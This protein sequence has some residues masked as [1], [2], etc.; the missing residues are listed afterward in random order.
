MRRVLLCCT[1]AM[2]MFTSTAMAQGTPAPKEDTRW[3]NFVKVAEGKFILGTLPRM[4]RAID[5][6][7]LLA[8][9]SSEPDFQAVVRRLSVAGANTVCFDLTGY[10]TDG[11]SLPADIAQQ[12]DVLMEL[13]NYSRMGAICRVIPKDA[14]KSEAFCMSAV[15]TAAAALKDEQRMVYLFDGPNS[16]ALVKVFHEAAPKLI[17]LAP[18]GGDLLL[19]TKANAVKNAGIPVVLTGITPKPEMLPSVHF[20]L[21]DGEKNLNAMENVLR[22]PVETKP[23][24]P[25]N[26]VL[27]EQ[28]RAEGFISLFNGKNLDG[29]WVLGDKKDGFIVKDGVIAWNGTGGKALYTRDCYDNFILRLEWK[30]EKKNGNSGL[31]NRAPRTNRQ[32][33]SGMEIQ[34]QG[35]SGTPITEQTTGSIYSVVAPKINAVKPEGEWNTEEVTCNGPL[36]KIILNGQLVQDTNLDENPELKGRLRKGFIGLQDHS[37]AVE[38][39]NLRIKKL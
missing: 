35:D 1:L 34:I 7:A 20:I 22:D 27:T 23:W 11:T 5:M 6:P 3:K 10:N 32:S 19:A 28:E 9:A 17:T 14:P 30:I 16:E 37:S 26:S 36:V 18:K 15:K 29:W 21:P 31:Y 39:R 4:M 8:T 24:K 2:A 25:D 13:A 12:V 33:K 38:F